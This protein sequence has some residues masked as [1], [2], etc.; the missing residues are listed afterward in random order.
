VAFTEA[1]FDCKLLF[2]KVLRVKEM[3]LASKLITCAVI[4]HNLAIQFGDDCERFNDEPES[5]PKSQLPNPMED[6]GEDVP[7]RAHR[8]RRR[9]QFL[10]F[11]TRN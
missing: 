4:L 11:F 3:T 10:H 6:Q 7:M 1:E 8:E 9:N 5:E 2:F